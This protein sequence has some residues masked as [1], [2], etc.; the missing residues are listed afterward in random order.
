MYKSELSVQKWAQGTM[1]SSHVIFGLVFVGLFGFLF[2]SLQQFSSHTSEL[3]RFVK[4]SCLDLNKIILVLFQRPLLLCCCSDGWENMGTQLS[5]SAA[6]FLQLIVF[7]KCNSG[8]ASLD[9]SFSPWKSKVE[10]VIDDLFFGS[11][12]VPMHHLALEQ[13]SIPIQSLSHNFSLTF[14][15]SFRK[16]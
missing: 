10:K 8:F 4:K 12:L 3:V 2:C 16:W 1:P 14:T 5:L 11:L 15:V 7:N 6:G 13:P 9:V